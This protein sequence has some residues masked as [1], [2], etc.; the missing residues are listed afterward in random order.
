M[1]DLTKYASFAPIETIRSMEV[2]AFVQ[3]H[4]GRRRTIKTLDLVGHGACHAFG[5]PFGRFRFVESIA[6]ADGMTPEGPAAPAPDNWLDLK[7]E[8][9]G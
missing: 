4:L 6:S 3:R 5:S 9:P 8:G 7:R 2:D 1:R